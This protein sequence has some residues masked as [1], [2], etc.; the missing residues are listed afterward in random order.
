MHTLQLQ[1]KQLHKNFP[2][3]SHPT[4][5]CSKVHRP[6]T[7][8]PRKL[9]LFLLL[10]AHDQFDKSYG[11]WQLPFSEILFHSTILLLHYSYYAHQHLPRC[12]IQ[13]IFFVVL[14][15]IFVD[16]E[17]TFY[18][19]PISVF[20]KPLFSWFAWQHA[21]YVSLTNLA[22]FF[23]F[24]VTSSFLWILNFVI[25]SG[26]RPWTTCHFAFPWEVIIHDNNFHGYHYHLSAEKQKP[27]LVSSDYSFLLVYKCEVDLGVY[28]TLSSVYITG[29]SNSIPKK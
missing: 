15:L 13:M 2:Q 21:V 23:Q 18:I 14:I 8:I 9:P 29:T 10:P 20:L 1:L 11:S 28:L 6:P 12:L 5:V 19:V 3:E 17:A 25:L 22:E 26:L 16:L 4:L 27:L 24:F 7:L